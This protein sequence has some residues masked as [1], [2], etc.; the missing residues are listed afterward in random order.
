MAYLTAAIVKT[1]SVFESHS[2]LQAFSSAI[3]HISVSLH[4]PSAS[5]KLLVVFVL[6][7]LCYRCTCLVPA[8]PGGPGHIPEEQ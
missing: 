7:L 2:L 3:F 1:L 5:A 6:S 4:G 8:H